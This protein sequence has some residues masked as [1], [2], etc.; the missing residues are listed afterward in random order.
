[1]GWVAALLSPF[2]SS[3]LSGGISAFPNGRFQSPPGRCLQGGEQPG[4]LELFHQPPS[5]SQCGFGVLLSSHLPVL[6]HHGWLHSPG[7]LSR[8]ISSIWDAE[9]GPG[10]PTPKGF[11]SRLSVGGAGW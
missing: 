4:W 6:P 7:A 1:M 11:G 3:L 8:R 9:E 10:V 5:W 2:S